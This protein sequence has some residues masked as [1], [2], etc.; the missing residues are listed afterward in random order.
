VRAGTP[1]R[2]L[3]RQTLQLERLAI[4]PIAPLESLSLPLALDGSAGSNRAD[5]SRNQ[6]G[7]GNDLAAIHAWL[8]MRPADS[9]TWRSYR[10]HA[11]RLLLWAVFQ[12][13]KPLSSL[14][15]VDIAEFMDFLADPA[16]AAMWVGPRT[17][18]RWSPAWRPFAGPLSASSRATARMILKSL[19]GWLVEMRYLD[20][21]PFK[22][23]KASGEEKEARHIQTS[24]SL[25]AAQWAYMVDH[26]LA[27]PADLTGSRARFILLFAYGTGLR[28][29]ELAGAVVGAL[30]PHQVDHALGTSW[31]LTVTGKGGKKR[32]VPMPK[33]VMQ[34][35]RA[36]LLLRGLPTDP[37]QCPPETP[38]IAR[39]SGT[40]NTAIKAP[41][42]AHAFKELFAAAAAPLRASDPHAANRLQ[43]ASTHWLRHTYGTH[44]TA[45][46]VPI[47]V[48]KDNFE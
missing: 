2:L 34:A 18:E 35:L 48:T 33:L 43:R 4:G 8:A 3:S 9:H 26:V 25:T 41:A 16:P 1:L 38:L 20:F 39:L 5:L 12:K 24:R 6:T 22:G 7:A 28:R 36:Y 21:N 30:T 19:C 15:V 45:A 27:R 17:A 42:L 46:G 37:E 47:D 44:A 40:G 10:T 29:A 32:D 13:R 31:V 14:N 11:E 23:S